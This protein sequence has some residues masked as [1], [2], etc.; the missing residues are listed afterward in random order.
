MKTNKRVAT[1]GTFDILHAGH[2]NLITNCY[3]LGE[4]FVGIVPDKDVFAYKKS[5]PVFNE[6]E[7][8][9]N[10]SLFNIVKFSGIVERDKEKRRKWLLDNKIDIVAMGGDHKNHFFLN[11]LCNELGIEYIIFER[12]KKIST[13]E[14]KNKISL[15]YNLNNEK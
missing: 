15:M 14:I 4:V 5:L 10:M 3:K 8:V 6:N 12:T 13:L 7:R 1:F 9:E 11:D 2:F